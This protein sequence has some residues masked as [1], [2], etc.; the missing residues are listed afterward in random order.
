MFNLDG[1][2]ARTLNRFERRDAQVTMATAMVIIIITI[3]G[4]ADRV[5]LFR[6]AARTVDFLMDRAFMVEALDS[7]GV[8][9]CT[10]LQFGVAQVGGPDGATAAASMAAASVAVGNNLGSR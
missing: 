10:P 4:T 9:R 5:L 8:V 1:P 3:M 2:I 6:L 7:D